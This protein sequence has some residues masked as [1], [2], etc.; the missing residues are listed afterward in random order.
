MAT[1]A[2]KVPLLESLQAALAFA[3]TNFAAFAPGA[4]LVALIA[5]A[6][7]VLA[8][9]AMAGND[10]AGTALG[11]ALM[12]A[13]GAVFY[14]ATL[15][16]AME[17][18]AATPNVLGLSFGGDELRLIA[19]MAV[20]GFFLFIVFTVGMI[21]AI[22]VFAFAIAPFTKDLQNAG[23]DQAAV[24]AILQRAIES[25][26]SVFLG[27]MLGY[28]F[29][30]MAL[31]SRLYLAAPATVADKA[32]RSFE[33]WAWTKG[34]MLRIIGVRIMLLV[35]AFFAASLIQSAAATALGLSGPNLQAALAA[36]Q[37]AALLVTFVGGFASLLLYSLMEA[38]LSAYLHRGLRPST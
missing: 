36:A 10:I 9:Q 11:M 15:R 30:W 19:A 3:R 28:G 20:V 35:P 21:P 23:N 12:G 17:L 2:G 26:P 38:G 5:V 7:N 25:N 34:N 22:A 1:P 13:I 32:I 33:T 24:A 16:R 6:P 31:T 18:P 37:P 8:A 29:L 14:A 27:L 4:A